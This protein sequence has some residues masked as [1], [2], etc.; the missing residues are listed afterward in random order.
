M[1]KIVLMAF[2][3]AALSLASCGNKS[4]ASANAD[5]TAT[6][7]T[8]AVDSAANDST[9]SAIQSGD[10]KAAPATVARKSRHALLLRIPR[11]LPPYWQTQKQKLQNWQRVTQA[12][13]RHTYHSC[14][15]I[16]ISTP[17]K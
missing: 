1:K 17:A 6:D 8:A 3:V 15:S 12:L 14:S 4:N 11:D 13:P 10:A 2:A 7:T 16:S 9:V 5:S